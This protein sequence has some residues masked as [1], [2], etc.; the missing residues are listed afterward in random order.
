MKKLLSIIFAIICVSVSMQAANDVLKIGSFNILYD[1]T[2]D[3]EAAWAG[4]KTMALDL[5]NTYDFDL[6]GLQEV[7]QTILADLKTID[8][9]GSIG[10]GINGGTSGVQ[11]TILYRKDRFTVLASGIFWLSATPDRVSLGWDAKNRRNCSWLKLQ[12]K[13]TNKIFYYINTHFDH[14]GVVARDESARLFRDSIPQMTE[15]YPAFFMGDLNCMEMETPIMTLKETLTDPRSI[16]LTA[17]KGPYGTGHGFRFDINVRRIDWILLYNGNGR[18]RIAVDSYEVINKKYDGKSP[19]DHWPVYI[20]ARLTDGQATLKVTSDKDDSSAG[21]LRAVLSQ[22]QA[23]DSIVVDKSVSNI[24]LNS[25]LNVDKSISINGQGTTIQVA[26][27]GVSA[28]K[29]FVFGSTAN[30]ETIRIQNMTI[31]GGKETNGAVALINQNTKFFA[32]NVIFRD[33]VSTASTG[34]LHVNNATGTDVVLRNC[35]FINNEAKSNAGGFYSKG[36]LVM[37]NCLFEGNTTESNGAALTANGTADIKNCIFRNNISRGTGDYAGAVFITT[38]TA[39]ANFDNCLFDSNISTNTEKGAGAFGCSGAATT[40]FRNSTFWGNSG[41]TAGVFYNRA[42]KLSLIN[43]SVSGNTTNNATNGAVYIY[44]ANNASALLVNT[45]AAYNYNKSG[46]KDLSVGGQNSIVSGE[47]NL[48]SSS[49]VAL[50]NPISFSYDQTSLYSSYTTTTFDGKT[51]KIPSLQLNGG[52]SSTLALASASVAIGSGVNASEG[53]T[54]PV[55]DQRLYNRNLTDYSLGA[56]EVTQ[57][58]VP[59]AL[60]VVSVNASNVQLG[61]SG[62][63]NNDYTIEYKPV[64]ESVWSQEQV[65]GSN[66]VSVNLNNLHSETAYEWR[67]KSTCNEDWVNGANF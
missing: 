34:G 36:S 37:D 39:V 45:I 63:S 17:P 31:K 48:V 61:W 29:P 18:N 1:N 15:G 42:G 65:S 54:L 62:D 2:T 28:Y 23:G 51:I 57:C 59:T 11:N 47:S 24:I 44:D 64:S 49:D 66:T 43:C 33:G 7:S 26:Q 6:L 20:Q 21:T 50:T 22:A 35:S 27:P 52:T 32:D 40:T 13:N 10:E 19:S 67:V 9:Y 25:V 46:Y 53:V 60:S 41:A 4:R 14:E 38:S 30:E 12:D 55:V 8:K 5:I 56:F 3:S 16:S 58:S